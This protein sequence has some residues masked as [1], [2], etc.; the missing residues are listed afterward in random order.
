[1]LAAPSSPR[2]E[3]QADLVAARCARPRWGLG[4]IATWRGQSHCRATRASPYATGV[5]SECRARR[6]DLLITAEC[7]EQLRSELDTLR[8]EG[9]R[10]MS[11]RLRGA[12][13]DGHPDDNPGLFEMLEG[14][15][16]LT[17]IDEPNGDGRAGIGSFIRP[18]DLETGKPVEYAPVGA[19]EGNVG[20]GTGSVD[21][22]VDRALVDAAAGAAISIAA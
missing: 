21:A 10:D 3:R 13:V 4:S 20:S 5:R 14:R 22:P 12:R 9:R 8:T 18:R 17:R 6:Y 11:E 19:I 16:A 15:L 1:M 7:Y 2:S